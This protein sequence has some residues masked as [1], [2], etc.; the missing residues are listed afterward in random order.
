[1]SVVTRRAKGEEDDPSDVLKYQPGIDEV[2]R[3]AEVVGAYLGRRLV[4]LLSGH[5]RPEDIAQSNPTVS[6]KN[7]MRLLDIGDSTLRQY[8]REGRIKPI[9]LDN[10]RLRFERSELERFQRVRMEAKQ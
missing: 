5:S 3:C 2:V 8:V 7:A 6:F 9:R 4:E 1:M 10:G